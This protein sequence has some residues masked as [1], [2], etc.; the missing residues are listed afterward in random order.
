VGKGKLMLKLFFLNVAGLTVGK[1]ETSATPKLDIWKSLGQTAG[2][3]RLWILEAKNLRNVEM[4]GKQDPYVSV[5]KNAMEVSS[6]SA[7]KQNSSISKHK[8]MTT[9]TKPDAGTEAYW[10]EYIDIAHSLAESDLVRQGA[11]CALNVRVMDEEVLMN[12]EIGTLTIDVPPDLGS[13]W[14]LSPTSGNLVESKK[15][16]P[17]GIL[18]YC[19]QFI[20]RQVCTACCSNLDLPFYLSGPRLAYH[21]LLCA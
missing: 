12:R 16:K 19:L 4:L 13:S 5:I 20:P 9:R 8:E 2:T 6:T 3:I 7:S 14:M 11:K 17:A 18:R 1:E 15:G 21:T 10:L